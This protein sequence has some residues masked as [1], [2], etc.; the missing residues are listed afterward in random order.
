MVDMSN[1]PLPHHET[2]INFLI[3]N[4]INKIESFEM[5][6]DFIINLRVLEKLNE[7][8]IKKMNLIMD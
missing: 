6:G 3:R 5:K 7:F 2:D 1:D 4:K 8:E